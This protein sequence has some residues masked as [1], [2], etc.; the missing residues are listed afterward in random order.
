M[1][2]ND[3][4][5]VTTQLA[6]WLCDLYG[7]NKRLCSKKLQFKVF[8]VEYLI[9]RS[10]LKCSNVHFP[11]SP[12]TPNEGGG[13]ASEWYG[14]LRVRNAPTR[15]SCIFPIHSL[16][17]HASY[18]CPIKMRPQSETWKLGMPPHI[19]CSAYSPYMRT[20]SIHAS[21]MCPIG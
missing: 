8:L 17:S 12:C 4:H 7:S 21:C 14:D 3:L 13:L 5:A 19:G 1:W 20:L 2:C 9:C 15:W 16:T 11:G 10:V 6:L 18:M